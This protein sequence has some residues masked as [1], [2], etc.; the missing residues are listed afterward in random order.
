MPL[1]FCFF[2][3][4]TIRLFSFEA[5]ARGFQK[6]IKPLSESKEKTM[7]MVQGLGQSPKKNQFIEFA[8]FL[9]NLAKAIFRFLS[10]KILLGS[11]L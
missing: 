8:A 3:V 4:L 2:A 6:Y 9:F 10:S 1:A 5:Q 7:K 11:P